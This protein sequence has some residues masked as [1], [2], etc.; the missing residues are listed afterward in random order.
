MLI[1]EGHAIAVAIC[2]QDTTAA[3]RELLDLR[4]EFAL[5]ELRYVRKALRIGIECRMNIESCTSAGAGR[6]IQQRRVRIGNVNHARQVA[7][8]HRFQRLT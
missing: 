3:C 8:D 4:Q 1:N 5:N 2:A 6:A 7:A